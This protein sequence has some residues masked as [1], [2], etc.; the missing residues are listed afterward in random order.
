MAEIG[1]PKARIHVPVVLSKEEVLRLLNAVDGEHRLICQLLYGAGLRLMECLRLRVKDLDFDRKMIIVREGKGAKDR[2]VMLPSPLAPA[3]R[4]QLA[5]SKALWMEDRTSGVA[6]VYL[7]DA[8]ARK[9]PRAPESWAWHWVFP[10]P[11]L[12]TDPRTGIVRRHHLF[13]QRI[14]RAI[15]RAVQRADLQKKVTAHTLRHTFATHLL[16]SGVDIRR[17][18]ELLGHTDVSTTMIYTHVLRSSAAG[19][20]SPLEALMQT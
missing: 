2:I 8:L 20:P 6:G 18:Q 14:G 3:L 13:E 5:V 10:S 7:P 9:Y 1:R 16:D 17:V 12:A 15:N 11:H 19:T 4:E